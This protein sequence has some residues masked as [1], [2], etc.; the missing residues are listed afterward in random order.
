[1]TEELIQ[2][3]TIVAPQGIKGELR[4][5]ADSDF[6]ERFEEPGQRWLQYP[7]KTTPQ[8]V[9]LLAGYPIPGKNIYVIR[10]AE[11]EDRNQ[12]ET[13]RG[14]KLLVEKS[15]RPDLEED[16]Y[17]VSDLINLE[18]Y[19]QLTGENIGLVTNIFSAGNDLLEVTLHKQ[20]E[21]EESTDTD[22]GK[23]N[24]VSKIPKKS[25]KKPKPVTVWIPFVKDIVQIVDLE[26]GRIEINPPEGLLE[27]KHT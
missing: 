23:I 17:H 24:R 9:E 13:L 4:V 25:N 26:A 12:A 19:H 27:I 8:I 21:I 7:D 3:G 15:D 5:N 1:M 14:C 10:L 11:I 20:P 18:V 16:E 22:I 6:P 2:I